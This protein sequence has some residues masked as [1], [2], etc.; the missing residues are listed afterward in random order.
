[1]VA[2]LEL[3]ADAPRASRVSTRRRGLVLLLSL[4]LACGGLAASRVRELE[5]DVEARVGPRCRWWWRRATWSPTRRIPRAALAVVRVP[6]RYVPPD[7]LAAVAGPR[8]RGPPR[9]CRAAA[10]SR[11]AAC[12]AHGAAG[13]PGA[14]RG[15]ERAVELAVAGGEALAAAPPGT[16]VDVMVSSEPGAGERPQRARAGGGGAA[17]SGPLDGASGDAD[18]GSAA[19]AT[20]LATLRVTVRQA[21]Y[22]A[23]AESFGR[24]VRL[25]VRPPGDRDR[26]GTAAVG[27][28]EL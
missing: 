24:E 17:G 21:V 27:A 25:L 14:L 6:A 9:P 2:A 23:A 20:A 22:L 5:R 16:R 10:R 11:R 3:P 18:E 7:A 13:R 26:V 4:A 19:A 12:R 28:G 1:M 15:G 8:V